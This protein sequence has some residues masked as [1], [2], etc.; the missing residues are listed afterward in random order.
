MVEMAGIEY[1]PLNGDPVRNGTRTPVGCAFVKVEIAGIEYHPL[2][3]DPV[4]NG[5]RTLL[6]AR[7]SKWRCRESNIIP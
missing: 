5:T 3:G 4:R 1:H 7:S 6:G 2:N